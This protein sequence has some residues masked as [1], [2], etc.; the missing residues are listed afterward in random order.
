MLNKLF[1]VNRESSVF[2]KSLFGS[3]LFSTLL[4]QGYCDELCLQNEPCQIV[5]P[6]IEVKTGYFFFTHSKMRK[7]YDKGGWDIQLASSYPLWNPTDRFS[8]NAYAAVEY[9][10]CE[11]QS[12][13]GDQKTS[14]WAVPI[15]IGFKPVFVICP[16]AQY[17]F[18]LGPR[19]FYIHQHNNSC[20]VDKNKSRNGV[21]FFMNT[22]FDF[23]LKSCFAF[24]IFGE[25]AYAKTH[26]HSEKTGVYTRNIQVS[27][28]TLGGGLGYAF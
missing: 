9:F 27:G 20:D 10:H 6:L 28:F 19:Y 26:F 21:G 14:L 8:L 13:Q 3:I 2:Y 25:Y 17:Y 22:G 23:L 11:G 16:E 7:V 4:I 18:T 1:K 15:N 24:T 5:R 12:L